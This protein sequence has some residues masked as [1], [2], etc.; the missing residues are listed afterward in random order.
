[1]L[2]LF[3]IW[4]ES[5]FDQKTFVWKNFFLGL[6]SDLFQGTPFGVHSLLYNILFY[7]IS[8]GFFNIVGSSRVKKLLTISLMSVFSN[9]ILSMII[10][11]YKLLKY[12]L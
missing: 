12:H 10:I 3:F 8:N 4:N 2:T 5:S 1:M 11:I 6:L 7:S 9:I